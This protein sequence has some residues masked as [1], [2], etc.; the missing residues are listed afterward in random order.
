MATVIQ[1]QA[2]NP[3][4]KLTAAVAATAFI[5]VSRVVIRNIAPEWADEGMFDALAPVAV[6]I[7]G[8]F[9]KDAPNVAVVVK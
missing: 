6:L 1:P 5:S 7:F 2:L 3:T 4:N 8:W 9:I